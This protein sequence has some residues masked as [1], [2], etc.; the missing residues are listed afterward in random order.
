MQF[1]K[2]VNYILNIEILKIL[3][4]YKY[5]NIYNVSRETMKLKLN[6]EILYIYINKKGVSPFFIKIFHKDEY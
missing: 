6:I 4:Y 2:R 1:A 5:F 3:K